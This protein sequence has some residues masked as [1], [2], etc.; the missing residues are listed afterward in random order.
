MGLKFIFLYRKYYFSKRLFFG[1]KQKCFL[2]RLL[3]GNESKFLLKI[4][5]FETT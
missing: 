4:A 1:G 2:R 3:Q 5:F